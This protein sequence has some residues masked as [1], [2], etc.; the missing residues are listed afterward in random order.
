MFT[1]TN[2]SNYLCKV[3]QLTNPQNHPNA[4][5]LQLWN[6]DG[7]TVITDLSRKEGDV[8]VYFPP[9]C[10][11]DH[12][13]V[14]KLNLYQDKELNEDQ[15]QTGYIGKQRRVKCVKLRDVISEGMVLPLDRVLLNLLDDWR[16][17][18][19]LSNSIGILFDTVDGYI[20][21]KKY[22]PE[23]KEVRSGGGKGEPK[24][25]KLKDILVE[26]QFNFHYDTS[27]LQDNIHKFDEED[28]IVITDKWHGTSV[29]FSNVLTKRN[30]TFWDKIK[31]FFGFD[32]PKE[33]YKK[34]YSSRTVIK[35]IED[36]YHTQNQG[37]YNTDIYGKVFNE[38]KD[39]LF[40]G[41]TIYGEI[42]GYQGEKMIQ[43][44]YAYGCNPGEHKFLVYRITMTDK[45]GTVTECSWHEVEDF[46]K[47]FDL[48][49]VPVLYKGTI[50]ELI[51]D[52]G[53][54]YSSFLDLLKIIYLEKDCP[55]NRKGIP[56][57]G[58]CVRNESQ[59]RIAY[60]LKS[61]RFLLKESVDLDSQSEVIE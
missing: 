41:Y 3:V 7:Y 32:I 15:T 29:V 8:C 6:V 44:D 2:N 48:E 11:I 35:H 45:Y 20:I 49:I 37:Y 13:L 14:S 34:M 57:E 24:G 18:Y 19:D 9:E 21:S 5:S 42:V 53:D 36:K 33:E 56:A 17:G 52:Y 58:I 46:C 30:F 40:P 50:K 59:N 55:Y 10:Q 54:G 38:I 25:S 23:I 31:D 16:T 43:K 60:K 39:V 51:K 61:K 28:E 26:G 4:H 47:E 22:V 27:K 12:K 1:I